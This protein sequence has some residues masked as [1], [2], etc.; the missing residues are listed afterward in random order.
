METV[1][2]TKFLIS[3]A[4]V[5][6]GFMAIQ[7]AQAGGFSMP[8]SLQMM[9]P[10]GKP[11]LLGSST[12]EGRATTVQRANDGSH[13]VKIFDGLRMRTEVR[14]R[15]PAGVSVPDGKG[16]WMKWAPKQDD[17]MGSSDFEGVK[18]RVRR[19]DVGLEVT[20]EDRDGN[21]VQQ[22]HPRLAP[23]VY[24]DDGF[25]WWKKWA[26]KP[27]SDVVGSSTYQG[28]TTTVVRN[29]DGSH[30][31]ITDDGKGNVRRVVQPKFEP[32][33]IYV[34]DGKGGWKKHEPKP[35]GGFPRV[36]GSST[37]EGRTKVITL[38]ADGTHTVTVTDENGH[39]TSETHQPGR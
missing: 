10:K 6:A 29:A 27:K 20:R 11:T 38:N 37:Y 28:V 7:P 30:T 32:G 4:I 31:V 35:K 16:G 15:P 9:A 22:G 18:T 36:I 5:A 12:F 24:V 19:T 13:I 34:D 25:G 2:N 21:I 23:G 14:Q 33:S 17:V 8:R 1:M 3:T 26:P 39:T